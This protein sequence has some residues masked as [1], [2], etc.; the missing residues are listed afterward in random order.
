MNSFTHI[1]VQ[2]KNVTARIV[3]HQSIYTLNYDK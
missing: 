3:M 1:P 2:F